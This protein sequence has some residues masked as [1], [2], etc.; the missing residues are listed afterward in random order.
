MRRQP[1]PVLVLWRAAWFTVRYW[2]L[3]PLARPG[4]MRRQVLAR[5]ELERLGGLDWIQGRQGR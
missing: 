3:D 1:G 4:L 2:G 5:A